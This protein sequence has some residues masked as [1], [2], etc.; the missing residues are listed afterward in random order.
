MNNEIE[1]RRDGISVENT[2]KGTE[3]RRDDTK[4]VPSLR[5]SEGTT[6]PFYQYAAPT[7]LV[8]PKRPCRVV[9]IVGRPNV[10]KSAIFN[11]LAK[12]RIAIVHHQPGV[13]RDRLMRDVEWDGANFTLMDT[14]GINS[15]PGEKIHDAMDA[16][17]KAQAEAAIAEAAVCILVVD[18]A[19]GILPM[20]TEMARLLRK[21]G[22]TVFVAANKAD[23]AAREALAVD[24]S[25]LGFPVYPV[26]ALHGRGFGD[27]MD[28]VLE[29]L[30][31]E[32][33]T[34]TTP[35]KAPLNVAIVGRPNAGKSSLV[36]RLL[37]Q[38][39]VLVTDIPGTTRDSIDVPFTLGEGEN[40]RRYVLIDTAGARRAAR[41]DTA[42]ERY[43]RFRMEESVKRADIAV[44]M[45]DATRG[46]GLLDKQLAGMI[47]DEQKGCL[48]LVNKWDLAPCRQQEYLEQ[49]AI[50]L[51]F[52]AYC[53][54]VF[55]SA[56]HGTRLGAALAAID[57]IA[58]ALQTTLSTGVLNRVI[59]RAVE[60][61]PPPA[62]GGKPA[63]LYYATQTGV[64][65]VT[66]R[67]FVNDPDRFPPHY[68][69]Y[70][71]NQLR[72]AFPLDGA[73]LRL[74]F[75]ARRPPSRDTSS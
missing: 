32:D 72:A 31:P 21:H 2:D 9:A 13:T 74:H 62:R 40:A 50:D 46:V 67:L 6:P 20:D 59:T 25:G 66:L 34:A 73:P 4:D 68:R 56:K 5:D 65:P 26:S 19:A 48:V 52:M 27:L 61:T 24:F 49:L 23:D 41:V 47:R 42:V 15:A 63:R 51:P 10:G 7:G 57:R 53:P 36:N 28:R 43:S 75:R 44:L 1:S 11:R 37:N 33:A 69:D 39:R 58:A 18:I 60:K 45:I 64:N 70:L 12:K 30:P 71:V 22:M 17:I 8:P 54:A 3:S 38:E 16:G 14:G 29:K 35:E 55:I